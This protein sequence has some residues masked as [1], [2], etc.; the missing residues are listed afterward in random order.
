MDI[1][2]QRRALA[3]FRTPFCLSLF[4]VTTLA[5]AFAV[6]VL[7]G[8]QTYVR[9][10]N[11]GSGKKRAAQERPYSHGFGKKQTIEACVNNTVDYSS[12]VLPCGIPLIIH[13]SWKSHKLPDNFLQW[14]KTFQD[15]H[16]RWTYKLWTDDDND[17][18]VEDEFP[19]FKNTY[20]GFK[21]QIMRIDVVRFL[22]MYKYGGVY[23][24]LD[25]ESL[26]N[27]EPL[28]KDKRGV[29]VAQ[30]GTRNTFGHRIPNAWMASTPGHP[31]WMYCV[32]MSTELHRAG[33]RQAEAVAGPIMLTKAVDAWHKEHRY[34]QLDVIE[35]G[36]I[37]PID[38]STR[39]SDEDVCWPRAANDGFDPV[40]CKERYPDAYAITY[41]T[42]SWTGLAR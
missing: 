5:V 3:T 9:D 38:W 11:S 6:F 31:F 30:M 13:Q 25:F 29:V 16:A 27:L 1:A 24:D 36:L 23:A 40:K 33:E 42:H 14:A 37:Y 18:L 22:Y 10:C 21:S 34:E 35:P 2:S 12:G 20:K 28:L 19:W 15:R 8:W 39:K 26:K 41:W 17:R 32:H 7:V 4:K